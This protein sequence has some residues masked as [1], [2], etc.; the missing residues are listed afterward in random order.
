MTIKRLDGEF[1]VAKLPLSAVP[2]PKKYWF[3]SRTD[4]ELSVV[5]PSDGLP[6]D[7]IEKEDGWVCYKIEGILDFSLIGIIAEIST[8]L[9]KNS[10]SIFVVSTY[11]T[12]YF[13]VKNAF[14]DRVDE[15]LCTER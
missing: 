10:I 5:C 15:L 1:V 3:L 12:D 8:I 7:F 4:E 9:A 6:S 13:L 11:N 2:S 14:A